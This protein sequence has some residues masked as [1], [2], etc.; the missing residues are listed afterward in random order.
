MVFLSLPGLL[1]LLPILQKMVRALNKRELQWILFLSVGLLGTISLLKLFFPSFG[2]SG[3]FTGV[4][5][6]T[7][8]GV[9]L[10]G[11]YAEKYIC[12]NRSTFV[13]ASILFAVLI[14]FQTIATF[15]FYQKDS[16]KYL[17]LD[18]RV[19]ITITLSTF[20]FYIMIKY[21][22]IKLPVRPGVEKAIRYLGSLTFGIYLLSDWMIKVSA[23]IQQML[24]EHLHVIPA[25]ILWELLIF[26]ACATITAAL[27]QLAF[28]KKWI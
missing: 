3:Y 27:K 16:E 1:C 20:C 12:L 18:N 17:L 11:Y 26:V 13:F 22:F 24:Q 19:L 7:Y 14:G 21:C 23:P 6:S 28:I 15:H 25:M 5:F 8:I 9:Y 10:C 2:V 4:L